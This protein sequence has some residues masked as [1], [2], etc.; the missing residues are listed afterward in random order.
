MTIA[1]KRV[2]PRP[3]GRATTVLVNSA[4]LVMDNWYQRQGIL[5]AQQR[6]TDNKYKGHDHSAEAVDNNQIRESV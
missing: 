4:A 2:L 6:N 5:A 1:A 3:V